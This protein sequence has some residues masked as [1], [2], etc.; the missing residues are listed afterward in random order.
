M[1]PATVIAQA[2][3]G[4][5]TFPGGQT[6]A[7]LCDAIGT[8]VATWAVV[9]G[10]IVVQG[11]TQG[12]IGS[13]VVTGVLQILGP[14]SIVAT[15]MTFG[16][17]VGVTTPQVGT[18]IGLG[19]VTSLSG[20]LPY[21]GVSLGVGLGTD[22]SVVTVSNP[23][24]LAVALR[25]AHSSLTGALGGAGA[26]LPAFYTGIALGIAQLVQ[27]GVT[28]GTGVVAPSGPL[29]PGSGVGTSLS[30]VV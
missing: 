6:W 13:G 26:I 7:F 22:L 17:L 8:A 3:R 18:A 12:V 19:L 15:Q 28:L 23:A 27:T 25:L 4:S 21:Q 10:N 16:G 2:I 29:G 14:P 9:P 11:V 30:A 1:V 20:A 5:A 24:T